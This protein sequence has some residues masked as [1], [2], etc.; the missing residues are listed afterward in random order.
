LGVDVVVAVTGVCRCPASITDS[1][2]G[3]P[4][5]IM[6]SG[7]GRPASIMDSESGRPA[8]IIDSESRDSWVVSVLNVPLLVGLGKRKGSGM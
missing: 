2:S 3:Y 1:E 7:S 5:S 4:A 8:S 6:D